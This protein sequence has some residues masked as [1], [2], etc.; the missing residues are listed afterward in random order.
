VHYLTPPDA[1]FVRVDNPTLLADRPAELLAQAKGGLV[2][3]PDLSLLNTMQQKGW[4][5]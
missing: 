2:F 3:V 4:S 1:P 5:C